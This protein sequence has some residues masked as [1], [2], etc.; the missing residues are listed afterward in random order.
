MKREP[1][2]PVHVEEQP[3]RALPRRDIVRSGELEGHLRGGE[4][5]RGVE[6]LRE[7]ARE[8]RT[9]AE[10]GLRL[11][12]LAAGRRVGGGD[13]APPALEPALRRVHARPGEVERLAIAA[14]ERE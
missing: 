14:A 9:D 4:G 13:R 6:V 11:G 7:R 3:E 2:H 1:E 12:R 10:I 5:L 8:S